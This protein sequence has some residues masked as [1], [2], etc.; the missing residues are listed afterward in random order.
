MGTPTL[1]L[2]HALSVETTLVL[3]AL[4]VRSA[5]LVSANALILG[6]CLAVVAMPIGVAFDAATLSTNRHR[7]RAVL[8]ALTGLGGSFA[9]IV[10]A[11]L[12]ALAMAV[13]RARHAGGSN[14]MRSGAFTSRFTGSATAQT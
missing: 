14:A 8:I 9:A 2:S 11:L 13:A 10:V 4:F 1:L 5:S 12:I 7:T 6:T 3:R